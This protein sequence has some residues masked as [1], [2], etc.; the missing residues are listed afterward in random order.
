MAQGVVA[1]R[2]FR[3]TALNSRGESVKKRFTLSGHALIQEGFL[4]PEHDPAIH[5]ERFRIK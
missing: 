5:F 4:M 1:Y 3:S 2:T